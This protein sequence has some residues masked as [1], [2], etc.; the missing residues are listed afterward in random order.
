[1]SLPLREPRTSPQFSQRR[2]PSSH[3]ARPAKH[4][5]IAAAAP[6]LAT[7]ARLAAR[8]RFPRRFPRR[9][10]APRFLPCRR[11]ITGCRCAVTR[12]LPGGRLVARRGC[13]VARLLPHRCGFVTRRR[14]RITWFAARRFV[15]LRG[16]ALHRRAVTRGL[17]T[18]C[19]VAFVAR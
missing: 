13:A 2:W 6:R 11:F 1:I 14:R 7:A 18:R 9:F 16:F 3:S 5:F 10:A 15:T 12:L 4:S 8:C 19:R 17:L